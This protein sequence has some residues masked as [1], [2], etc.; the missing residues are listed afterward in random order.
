MR[1]AGYNET[2]LSRLV[3]SAATFGLALL[4]VPMAAN[5]TGS[6]LDTPP[7]K[8]RSDGGLV[9]AGAEAG[10]SSSGALPADACTTDD[11]CIRENPGGCSRWACNAES[12]RCETVS[13]GEGCNLCGSGG[14]LRI[15]FYRMS[16]ALAALVELPDGRHILIDTGDAPTRQFCGSACSTA[17]DHLLE[18]LREDLDGAP[19]DMLWITHPHSDHIGGAVGVLENFEVS[20][21]VDNGRD[22]TDNQVRIVHD[23]ATQEAT[24]TVVEPNREELPIAGS[25]DLQIRA[26]VPPAWLAQCSTDRNACSILLRIDYCSSSVLFTGDAEIDEEEQ[27]DTFGP[28][29]LLQVGHHG[30]ST[31]SGA[32]FLGRVQPQYAVVSSGRENEGLNTTYCHPRSE[33]IQRVSAAM[34]ASGSKTLRAFDGQV[35]CRGNT[36]S[37]WV[38]VPVHDRLWST[39]RDGDVTLTTTGD[40]SFVRE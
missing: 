1:R 6:T 39:A 34:G 14:A 27:I 24:M 19:I 8:P 22:S 26:I 40:G 10:A 11:D 7:Q 21:Y 23:R 13:L 38:D 35:S 17:H 33:T 20:H 9:E 31:S 2:V 25:G 30:S 3:R 12:Q 5:C 15:R 16:Q 32:S 37:H 28:A 29:T 36:D 4:V 18:R